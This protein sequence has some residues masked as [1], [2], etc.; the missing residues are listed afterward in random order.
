MDKFVTQPF[1]C[2]PMRWIEFEKE[3]TLN[4]QANNPTALQFLFPDIPWVLDGRN[5]PDALPIEL[6]EYENPMP[7]N[8]Q[9][10]AVL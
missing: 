10:C 7:V 5:M 1:E 4:L 9:I 8:A 2:E 6:T 3:I